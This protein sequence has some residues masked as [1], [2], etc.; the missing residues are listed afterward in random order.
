MGTE[1]VGEAAYRGASHRIKLHLDGK[2]LT[3]RDELKLSIPLKDVRDV[4]TKD[5]QLTIKWSDDKIVLRV[6]DKAAKLADKILHP[7]SLLDKLGIK[8][9]HVVSIIG[10]DDQAFLRDIRKRTESVVVGSIQPQ[11]DVV[12]FRPAT[13]ADLKRLK[14]LQKSLKRDGA[15]WVL[16]TKGSKNPADATEMDVI[17]T[18]RDSGLVDVKISA[19]SDE[20]TAMKVVIPKARR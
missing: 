15:I 12:I 10:F 7:P 2:E 18:A 1:I 20:L 14:T 4:A 9:G 16:R 3:L 11:S 6:G 13:K 19:F 5:G 8:L 17:N